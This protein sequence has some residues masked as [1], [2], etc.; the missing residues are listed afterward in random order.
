MVKGANRRLIVNL[1]QRGGCKLHHSAL[2]QHVR[3]VLAA[4][5]STRLSNTLRITIKMRVGLSSSSKTAI[6]V[7][8]WRDMSKSNAARSKHYTIEVQR[9][10]SLEKQLNTLTH[11]LMHVV[12]M[13]QRRLVCRNGAYYWRA[14]GQTGPATRVEYSTPWRER[15]WEIEARAA[16]KEYASIFPKEVING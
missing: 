1:Q 16:E 10:M 3:D 4:M 11:E 7:C 8:N 9:D 12:Q 14:A 6:G 2:E 15:P 13:A 5:C